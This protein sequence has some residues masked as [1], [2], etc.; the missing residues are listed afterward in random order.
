MINK[1]VD[2]ISQKLNE[3]NIDGKKSEDLF[4]I[5]FLGIFIKIILSV[6]ALLFIISNL[7]YKIDSLLAGLGIGGIAVAFALQNILR[8]LFASFSIYFDKPFKVGDFVV[9]STDSGFI[10]NIGLKSTRIRTLQGEELIIPNNVITD[11]KIHNYKQMKKR[12]VLFVL[13]VTYDTKATKLKKI[14]L[15][16]K[17]IFESIAN[18]NLDRV[19]FKEFGAYSLNYEVVY[20]INSSN[21][22]EY[23]N[24][25]E[26][27]NLKIFEEFEK[28]GIEFAYPTQTV[29]IEKNK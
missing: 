9:V 4:A 16:I 6:I 28:E 11:E 25:Q 17:E 13:G 27:V 20:Y 18:T 23:M 19:N 10:E 8:D 22:T 1:S 21:Y 14:N 2:F 29:I 24:I 15:I 3:K 26:K 5:V 12:R 7:G